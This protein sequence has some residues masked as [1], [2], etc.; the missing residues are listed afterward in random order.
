MS[1]LESVV[2]SKAFKL[3][4]PAATLA[5][6]QLACKA[7]DNLR[8]GSPAALPAA[9]TETPTPTASAMAQE[10][11]STIHP[12]GAA[13]TQ[14]PSETPTES[15]TPTLSVP[16]Q[17]ATQVAAT[18]GAAASPTPD[19]TPTLSVPEQVAT[20][21]AATLG[22]AASPTPDA[23]PTAMP[24]TA[25]PDA[26]PT[27]MPATATPNLLSTPG[28]PAIFGA[29]TPGANPPGLESAKILMDAAHNIAGKTRMD[30]QTIYNQMIEMF[31]GLPL[32]PNLAGAR[33]GLM[34][35]NP[36]TLTTPNQAF[37]TEAPAGG[38][39]WVSTSYADVTVDGKTFNFPWKQDDNR[40]IFVMGGTGNADVT[41]DKFPTGHAV[42]SN[43]TPE[44]YHLDRYNYSQQS[45]SPE[46]FADQVTQSVLGG[47]NQGIG[48]EKTVTASFIDAKTGTVTEFIYDVQT[49]QWTKDGAVVPGGVFSATPET[50]TPIVRT[51]TEAKTDA[52]KNLATVYGITEA[53]ATALFEKI[54]TSLPANMPFMAN[55]V[56]G[57]FPHPSQGKNLMAPESKN[58]AKPS[59]IINVAEH[60][61]AA[62]SGGWFFGIIDGKYDLKLPS[63][64]GVAYNVYFIG[65]ESDQS[66][67]DLN[68]NVGAYD[69]LPKYNYVTGASP[70]KGQEG[71]FADRKVLDPVW[72]ADGIAQAKLVNPN[73]TVIKDVFVDVQN[74]TAVVFA[75]DIASG[76][77]TQSTITMSAVK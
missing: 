8:G 66:P 23:S 73:T 53:E 17:V 30:A 26:S 68:T 45:V 75:Y 33:E 5:G 37:T 71:Q 18:L 16:E 57:L 9:G 2:S 27:A 32:M 77:W 41:I 24:P 60:G 54:Y 39:T 1:K 58:P 62:Y 46:W 25:T 38:W 20:Q 64:Q 40:L 74:G 14:V 76:T 72:I 11:T 70:N 42:T 49:K 55:P 21:V 19:A 56:E 52:A 50:V 10:P 44:Q 35:A 12:I 69:Y 67:A 28:A 65:K 29:P 4:A 43:A 59:E 15:P 51:E 61:F 47:S 7:A 3:G 13:F 34:P 36:V 6:T 31:N 63:E 22:A 48:T